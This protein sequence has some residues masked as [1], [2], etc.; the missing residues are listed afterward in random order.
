M[1]LGFRDLCTNMMRFQTQSFHR[2]RTNIEQ[3]VWKVSTDSKHTSCFTW[4]EAISLMFN[5]NRSELISNE[6]FH[7]TLLRV[8]LTV[9]K[10]PLIH[11][12][13]YNCLYMSLLIWLILWTFSLCFSLRATTYIGEDVEECNNKHTDLS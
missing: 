3:R 6:N 7:T 8:V 10:L 13:Y 12:S 1:L 2:S 4:F 11:S 5:I 9:C